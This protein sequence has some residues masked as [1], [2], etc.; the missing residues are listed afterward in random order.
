MKSA[1]RT[2]L[3]AG[4]ILSLVFSLAMPVAAQKDEGAAAVAQKDEAAALAAKA[5]ADALLQAGK[6][7]EAIPLARQVLAI[8]EKQLGP[9]H[10]DVV[11]AIR[12]LATA[13][14]QQGRLTDA[15]P[16]FR[17]ALTI[18]E[19]AFGP[20]D[21]D[22]AESLAELGRLYLLRDRNADA[23]SVLGRAQEIFEQTRSHYQPERFAFVLKN[24]GD[25]YFRQGRFDDAESLLR[26]ALAIR[27]KDFGPD[28]HLVAYVLISLARLYTGQNRLAEAE[29]LYQRAVAI[30]EKR[31]G[32]DHPELG[33]S[34]SFL[35]D[36]RELQG[37]FADGKVLVK[38]ALAIQEKSFGANGRNNAVSVSRLG[39]LHLREGRLEEAAQLYERA[40][41]I[42]EKLW[43]PDS[44]RVSLSLT[45]LG[46][47]HQ[48]W[49][50]YADAESFFGRAL[51][52]K[53]E[54]LSP[55]HP[56]YALSLNNLAGL[57]K[58]QNRYADA[59]P[60]VQT[61]IR[62]GGASPAVALPVLL[63][64]NG[65]GLISAGNAL[66]DALNVVQRASQNSAAAAV[67]KL[68]VRLAA[69]HDHL[70]LMVRQ[71][72]DLSAEAKRLDDA[73]IAAVS[74]VPEQR[75]AA[76]EERSRD[77]LAAISVERG[78]LQKTLTSQFPDY[79]A[80]S[81]PQPLAAGDTQRL[82]S[83]DEALVA[84]YVG[85]KESYVFALTHD[86]A[87]WHQ[88]DLG[89]SALAERVARFRGGLDPRMLLDKQA[90]AENHIKRELFDVGAAHKLYNALLGP[91]EVLI[92]N[93]R[94][95]LVV[96][97]GA[98]TALPFH[99]LVTEAPTVSTPT[100]EGSLTSAD[101]LAYRNA[102]WL[103]KRQAVTVLPSIASLKAL[104]R[105]DQTAPARKPLIGFGNP[106][107]RP[108]QLER[109]LI[110]ADAQKFVTRA[111]TNFW[112][113]IGVDRARL[114][115]ALPRLPETAI[116]LA[117]IAAK[118][119]ATPSDIHLGADASESTVKQASLS[120]YRIVYFATHG[121][122]AGDVKDL[123]EPAL[124]LTIPTQPSD[125]D[126]GLLTASEVAQL[127][128]NADWVV[129]SAC[130]TMAGD[131][132][133]AEALSGLA[134]A[135]FYAGARALLV[136]HWPVASTQS[137]QFTMTVFDVLKDDPGLD[138]A[139]ALRRTMLAFLADPSLPPYYAY[140][141]I[142]GP[143]SLVGE[144][145]VH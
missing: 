40:L 81:N 48:Q 105:S 94:H 10:P 118:V 96:P 78:A 109:P 36:L 16:L 35:A 5:A 18:R 131:R 58:T 83:G 37:R 135:F 32:P 145:A 85:N 127:K 103:I 34:L 12:R 9:D 110:A 143:F 28:H 79:A 59:L 136:T 46:N 24:L 86:G 133:G 106:V 88:V 116:E 33:V 22:V 100:V 144:G 30:E 27:E 73:F 66:D 76:A 82:L 107:F 67:A 19:N 71:D 92:K 61:T 90:L 114:S 140:P 69:G 99:L 65:Q 97:S 89:Y 21:P 112:R 115:D 134:R 101:M 26:R 51:A 20:D 132:P 70:A 63:G 98:L 4:A 130:N 15:E 93:K 125:L 113:G 50:H 49:G 111:Y 129:L 57:Y 84:F 117:T 87:A 124:A 55:D 53:K 54:I 141:A 121:L 123:A 52:V 17:R 139:E 77:R 138:R 44:L 102:A 122:V 11:Y 39:D 3:R 42:R 38:R 25:V 60:L 128:L 29:A 126:D 14:L 108:D 6:Y 41:A 2:A 91:V 13:Y 68:A 43:G 62:N 56:D 31:L 8:R 23:E 95:L 137:A 80:L 7:S 104:R 47:L 142:W 45:Q 75:D 120:D 72:Q 64:A 119:G 74:R 1:S